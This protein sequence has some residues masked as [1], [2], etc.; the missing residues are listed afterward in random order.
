LALEGFYIAGS[1]MDTRMD[2][3]YFSIMK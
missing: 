2:T 1:R 3:A